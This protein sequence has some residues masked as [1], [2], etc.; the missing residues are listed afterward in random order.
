[1]NDYLRLLRV[2]HYIK[3]LL[4][5]IPLFFARELFLWEKVVSAS[6]GIICFSLVSS[7]IYILNDLR[8]IEK[9]KKHS[10][11]RNRPIASGRVSKRRAV[12]VLFLCLFISSGLSVLLLEAKGIMIL[13]IYFL[14]NVAYSMG[15]KNRPIL[16]IFI[17][18]SGFLLRIIY[19]G[20]LTNIEV[21]KYLYLI[22][23]VGALFMS[24][25]KRRNELKEQ[26]DTRE[27]G[28]ASCRE[29]V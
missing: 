11:K 13:G 26:K 17:L 10:T 1:M 23:I 4:I 20:L 16:D 24:L 6:W 18:A 3:N 5:F 19:G 9:D 25:G 8:D 15:L 27:I 21:S 7:A 29:R 28:R 14:I 12:V 22:V 2:R